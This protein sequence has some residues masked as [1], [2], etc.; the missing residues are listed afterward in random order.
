MANSATTPEQ[1]SLS[2]ESPHLLKEQ[3]ALGPAGELTEG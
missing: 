1:V 2:G 3:L